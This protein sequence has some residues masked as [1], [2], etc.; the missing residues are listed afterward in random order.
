MTHKVETR[1]RELGITLPDPVAP[2]GAYVAHVISGSTLY[3]SGQISL[4]PE[5]GLMTGTLGDDLSLEQ[6]Q[7][8]A[9][10]CGLNVLAQ[11]RDAV[12]GDWDR[13]VRCLKLGGFVNAVPGYPDHPKVLN[14]ASDVMVEVLGDAGRHVRF[15]VGANSL[16]LNIAVEVEATF[17]VRS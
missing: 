17:E 16:P 8:A 6:G 7:R 3:I 10:A 12:G 11:A 15:A 13:L 9:R 5:Q 4:E 2:V 1:L 14:G